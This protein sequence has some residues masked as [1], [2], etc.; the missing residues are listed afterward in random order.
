MRARG[1]DG[2][3][4]YQQEVDHLTRVVKELSEAGDAWPADGWVRMSSMNELGESSRIA[5]LR[6]AQAA[7]RAPGTT[8]PAPVYSVTIPFE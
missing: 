1:G 7:V 5:L 2:G 8:P 4:A 6:I 3:M